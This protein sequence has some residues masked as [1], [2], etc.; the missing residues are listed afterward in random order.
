MQKR[1]NR[2]PCPSL[3]GF[4]AVLCNMLYCTMSTIVGCCFLLKEYSSE[5]HHHST[6]VPTV[7]KYFLT[8]SLCFLFTIFIQLLS[9]ISLN[10]SASLGTYSFHRLKHICQVSTFLPVFPQQTQH[11]WLLAWLQW[12]FM[13]EGTSA[14]SVLLQPRDRS[15]FRFICPLGLQRS[16]LIVSAIEDWHSSVQ[17]QAAKNKS[18]WLLASVIGWL[19]AMACLAAATLRRAD[20]AALGWWMSI[21]LELLQWLDRAVSGCL[22]WCKHKQKAREFNPHPGEIFAFIY[23]QDRKRQKV[24]KGITKQIKTSAQFLMLNISGVGERQGGSSYQSVV[25]LTA[26]TLPCYS[27]LHIL[28]VCW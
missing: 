26:L 17:C 2:F 7:R 25:P 19:V 1:L 23:G 27:V 14:T 20:R 18:N 3:W 24:G 12:S 5:E 21:C 4:Q 16:P 9:L 22:P 28:S 11:W 15:S 8:E 6:K 13:K 10:L